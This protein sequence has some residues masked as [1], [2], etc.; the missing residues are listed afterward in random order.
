MGMKETLDKLIA[1]AMMPD[2]EIAVRNLLQELKKIDTEIL[3]E[4]SG[5]LGELCIAWEEGVTKSEDKANIC[6][7]LAEMSVLDTPDFRGSLHAAIRKLLPPYLASGAVVKAIGAKD[8]SVPAS[9]AAQRLRKLQRLRSTALVYQYDSF[10]WSKIHSIDNVTGTIAISPLNGGS[11]SSV[12]IAS[13]IFSLHFFNMT[14]DIMN[15][16][17]PGKINYRSADEYRKI[18]RACTLS[19][20]TDQKLH[21]IVQRIMIPDIMNRDLFENWWSTEGGAGTVAGTAASERAFW[22]ARSIFELYTLL[23]PLMKDGSVSMTA[24]AAATLTKLF[25][26]VKR[27]IQ[28]K[29]IAMLTEC[30]SALATANTAEVMAPVFQPLRGVVPFWP[31]RITKELPL[32]ALEAWGKL[33]VKNM[34]GF[35][36]AASML[37]TADELALLATMLPLK[38]IGPVFEVLP[39]QTV[40]STILAQKALSCDMILWIYRNRKALPNRIATAIDMARCISAL[41]V[42]KLPKEWTAAQRDLQKSL[43]DKADFQKYIIDNADGDIPSIIGG[44]QRY[45]HFQHGERQSVMVKLSRQSEEIKDY[46]ESGAGSKLM[47]AAAKTK[48]EK[49]PVTSLASHK[50]LSDEL[51]DL[52]SVQI[53]ENAAAVA[54]AR[55]YGDLRENA[56]YDAAKER[57]RFLHRRRAELEKT[58][59][60]IQPTAFKDIEINDHAVVGSVV[61]LAAAD[62]SE[63]REYYLLGAWDGD[64]EKRYISYK[65]KIGEALLDKKVGDV[66]EIPGAGKFT[67]KAVK[68][69]PESLRKALACEE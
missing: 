27:D 12:P 5:A 26:R 19:R 32:A 35:V 11:V 3:K 23:T 36:K 61:V 49:A 2:N 66:A 53:P 45:R 68:A 9:E 17:Y 40:H 7:L 18:F 22:N 10:Q 25:A 65:T 6:V 56:E 54:L 59:N 64:P 60:F 4:A 63:D 52:V 41:S 51:N 31:A 42:E 16:L 33:S 55:S 38:C 58:L 57:R 13:A 30:I 8:E 34:T 47:G 43:F 14:P 67:I 46:L 48:T 28:P 21:D 44:L 1:D 29:D 20:L 15:L 69:L 62:G 50:R 39:V 24:D 37:Y